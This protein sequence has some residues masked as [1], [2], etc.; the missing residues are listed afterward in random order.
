MLSLLRSGIIATAMMLLR[1]WLYVHKKA[2]NRVSAIYSLGN[3]P[4]PIFTPPQFVNNLDL[5]AFP[6]TPAGGPPPYTNQPCQ[7]YTWS[8]G[9]NWY[10]DSASGKDVPI[11]LIRFP[12]NPSSDPQPG[13]IFGKDLAPPNDDIMYLSLFRMRMHTG[14][15]N[16]YKQHYCVRCNR[17][18]AIV[19]PPR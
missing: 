14:F 9:G 15:P 10:H 2:F 19:L 18:G 12:D 1:L 17:V 5:W 6:G 16:V 13:W 11:I 8:K 3:P 7:I 4:M